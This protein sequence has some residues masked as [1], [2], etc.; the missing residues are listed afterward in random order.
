MTVIMIQGGIPETILEDTV[1]VG[2]VSLSD[3][4]IRNETIEIRVDTIGDSS[5]VTH[6]ELRQRGCVSAHPL[7]S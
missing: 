5:T 7:Y 2:L 6:S 1:T 3:F 4:V